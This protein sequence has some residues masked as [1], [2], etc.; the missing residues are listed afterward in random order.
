M[1]SRSQFPLFFFAASMFALGV[2]SLITGDIALVWEPAPAWVPAHTLLAHAAGVIMIVGALA[3]LF[4]RTRAGATQ[5]LL[6]YTIVWTLLELPAL[7]TGLLVEVNWLN[8]GELTAAL[9]GAWILWATQNP[10]RAPTLPGARILFGLSL[11][12]IGLSHFVYHEAAITFVPTWLPFRGF[13][14]TLTGAAHIAAGLG[15][16][17]SV[18]PYLAAT[19]EAVML[20]LFFAL[21]WVPR[22][23]ATPS[24]LASWRSCWITGIVGAAAWLL[25]ASIAPTPP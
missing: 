12:P 7:L 11:L 18:L 19:L 2:L 24:D 8:L 9:A 14:A 16:L 20:T 15:I 3:L 13:W 1:H 25:A 17:F 5:I 4:P 6:A 10:K 23:I 21:V 22:L